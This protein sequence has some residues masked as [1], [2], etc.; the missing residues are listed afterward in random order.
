[1]FR[2]RCAFGTTLVKMF[3]KEFLGFSGA[4]G[5]S[6]WREAAG[7]YSWQH[8]TF[9]TSLL[10]IMTVLAV[11]LG[12]AKRHKPEKEKNR[13]L[14]WA[15]ILIDA[16]E[17]FKI[18]I[19]CARNADDPAY[20][21][22]LLPLFLCSIQLFALPLAAFSGGRLK[23]VSLD[24]VMIFGILGAVVGTYGAAQNYGVY[25]V[26]SLENVSSGITHS[27]SGFASIYIMVSGMHSM[28]KKNIGA[29]CLILTFFCVLAYIVNV[30][31]DYNYMFL[32]DHDGTP[33]QIIY[34]LVGGH[35]VA[36]PLMVV[37]LFVVYIV[38]FYGI[39][40]AVCKNRRRSAAETEAVH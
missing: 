5:V 23:E 22:M 30:L 31:V 34:D 28:K 16:F 8:L 29:T 15:A 38:A 13:V 37:G 36:Y 25:P 9:V 4:D 35:K 21:Q 32:M 19:L 40:Y 39:Y 26:L 14:I 24:F 12:R 7:A 27:I 3:I 33:Y 18:V 10:V 20:W 17:I 1:M 6:Y 11:L 2:R